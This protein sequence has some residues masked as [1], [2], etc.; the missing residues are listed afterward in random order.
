MFPCQKVLGWKLLM[1]SERNPNY[2]P[3]V[4]D[5]AHILM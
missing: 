3:A 1:Q 5:G 2:L 4:G